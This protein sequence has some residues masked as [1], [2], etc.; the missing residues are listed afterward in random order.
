MGKV[1][2]DPAPISPRVLD[3]GEL[4]VLTVGATAEPTGFGAA[5]G[6]AIVIVCVV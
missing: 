5:I 3:Q 2:V 4:A 6:I 1:F